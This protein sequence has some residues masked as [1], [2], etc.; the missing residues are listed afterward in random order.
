MCS[1]TDHPR[2]TVLGLESANHRATEC[3]LRSVIL[4]TC[5]S[6]LGAYDLFIL[7]VPRRILRFSAAPMHATIVS[8][9]KCRVQHEAM[10]H[11]RS[12]DHIPHLLFFTTHMHAPLIWV[13]YFHHV[14][15]LGGILSLFSHD[16]R[17]TARWYDTCGK[18]ESPLKP[19]TTLQVFWDVIQDPT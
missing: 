15:Y 17:C 13:S 2:T 7:V 6:F 5:T 10:A 14:T 19:T 11:G 1:P 8:Q 9:E 3:M 4:E 18:L 16:R 12:A